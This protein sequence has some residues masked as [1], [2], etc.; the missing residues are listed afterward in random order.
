MELWL[1]ETESKHKGM[2]IFDEIEAK[3]VED[4]FFISMDGV[5]G[6][7]EGAH[8]IFPNAIVQRWMVHLIRISLKTCSSKDYKT[9]CA[10]LKKVY[11]AQK[12]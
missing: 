1:N 10:S 2:K 3:G 7:G 6:L 8:S 5:S 12:P 4:I 9:F 11:G